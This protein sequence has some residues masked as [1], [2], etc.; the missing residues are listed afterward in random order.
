MTV[1][2]LSGA[3]N[4]VVD[5]RTGRTVPWSELPRMPYDAP[6][7]ALVDSSFTAAGYVAEH[8]CTRGELLV[9]SRNRVDAALESEL[10][11]SGFRLSA[12][13]APA[14]VEPTVR[15]PLAGRLWLLTSG[16]TGRPKRVRHSLESLVTVRG[17]Q[18]P[19][20]WL[21]PYSPGSYAWWQLVGLSLSQPGQDLVL[22]DPA[23]LDDW[24]DVA[25]KHGVDAVS[26]TPTF[27][28]QALMRGG[29]RLADLRPA[30]ITLGGEPVDQ[31][32]LDVLRELFPAARISW[33]YAST[34]AGASVVVH[35]GRAGF[36]VAW[37]DRRLPGHPA[38]SVHGD[39]L[40]V[41]SPHQTSDLAGPVATGDR[42]VVRDE[43]VLIVG[44]LDTDEINVGGA[45]VSAAAVRD[46][47]TEHPA[48][49]WARAGAR[50]AP[51]VGSLV[52]ADVVLTGGVEDESA[53]V[54]DLT[55]WC[56]ERL[57]EQ[58]VP[59]RIR[60]LQSI[61]TKETLKSDV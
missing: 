32:V 10:R 20:R 53:A 58:G 45:K 41:E 1:D 28:R 11:A 8:A 61:P 22:V 43:R 12:A 14:P 26:G 59:R 49:A 25:V 3:S 36:P 37:L 2:V 4:L 9:A 55:G 42:V 33:I 6:T 50:R 30:Q 54:R 47:L 15:R 40:Y 29:D 39:E 38:L 44:R 34:E 51:V 52:V 46:V 48:V 7:A 60:F 31:A 16:S 21:C 5:G 18:P 19:R 13:G 23:D 17:S 27:W 24:V 57:P 35:D 56:R